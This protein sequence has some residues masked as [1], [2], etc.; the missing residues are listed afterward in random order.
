MRCGRNTNH[1]DQPHRAGPRLYKVL[2]NATE[3]EFSIQCKVRL[4]DIFYTPYGTNI[5]YFNKITRKHIDFLVCDLTTMKPILGVEL[6]DASHN[7]PDRRDRDA[8][9]DEIFRMTNFPLLHFK[10]Q[11]AYNTE[12][13]ASKVKK[14]IENMPMS[15][16][17]AN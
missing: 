12:E 8:F 13:I 10:V 7:Q 2:Q 6:D 1:N 4:A 11:Q 3:G 5:S 14:I 9:V 16:I 15:R 17:H